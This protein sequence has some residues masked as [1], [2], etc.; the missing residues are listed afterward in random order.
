[1]FVFLP[2]A[3]AS[4]AL[5]RLGSGGGAVTK[6][7]NRLHDLGY[8]DYHAA[9]GNYGTITQTAVVRFQKVNALAADGIAGP[10][11][12]N[13]L[14]SSSA[15]SLVLRAGSGGEAVRTM[16]L[17]LKNL[18]YFTGTGTGHFGAITLDAVKR[19][20]Q[21]NGL[22]VDG[23]AGPATRKKLFSNNVKAY[24]PANT[25]APLIADIALSQNG[26]PYAWGGIGPS[27]YDCSGLAY[28]AMTK[29]GYGISRLSSAGYGAVAS[30]PKITGRDGLAKGDLLFFRSDASPGV[31]H[32]GIYTGNG[33]FVHASSGQGRVMIST[34]DNTYW[35]R[36]YLFARRAV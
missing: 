17:K 35:T 10:A 36:N 26:K 25:S 6:L 23:I 2:N 16:Q 28:Y 24:R 22:A 14:Y 30:W 32:M 21:S 3:E 34:L 33:E 18:G 8:F 1:M 4:G 19:F 12:L 13:K 11:T 20:Q 15:K 31:G 7:Q 29:A 27:S 9:T 5:M